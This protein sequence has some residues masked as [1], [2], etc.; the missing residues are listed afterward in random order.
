MAKN[1]RSMLKK[2]LDADGPG[3]SSV[4]SALFTVKCAQQPK[5]AKKH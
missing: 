5:I 1:V 2:I 4:I 3:L